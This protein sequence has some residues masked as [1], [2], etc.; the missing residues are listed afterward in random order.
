MGACGGAQRGAPCSKP[1]LTALRVSA[2]SELNVDQT[3]QSLPVVLR[4]LQ[5][6]NPESLDGATFE[7]LWQNPAEALGPALVQMTDVTIYPGDT[8]TIAVRADKRAHF[9]GIM[10]IFREPA[11]RDW[12]EVVR[13]KAEPLGCRP[14]RDTTTY[15][16]VSVAD[17]ALVAELR[18][19]PV[20]SSR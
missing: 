4:L 8:Q 18:T 6:T 9:L 11:G 10:G 14:P 19:G 1:A 5:V 2:A 17:A 12:L 16:Q 15:A 3:G 20:E 7:L 13:L